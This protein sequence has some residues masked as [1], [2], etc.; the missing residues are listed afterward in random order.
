M[1]NT[2]TV[3]LFIWF[4][5][6][7]FWI[8]CWIVP[9]QGQ[10]QQTCSLPISLCCFQVLIN[11]S[12]LTAQPLA[13]LTDCSGS[14]HFILYWAHS[15]CSQLNKN[16]SLNLFSGRSN[17]PVIAINS[18]ES[19][20]KAALGWLNTGN[21]PCIMPSKTRGRVR[22]SDRRG[23]HKWCPLLVV[24]VC[25]F[26]SLMCLSS[27]SNR[28]LPILNS[29]MHSLRKF[30]R[31]QWP[32]NVKVAKSVFCVLLV[33]SSMSQAKEIITAKLDDC[34]KGKSDQKTMGKQ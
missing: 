7:H 9:E 21:P 17:A 18:A 28:G 16:R 26:F 32:A 8:A 22:S 12:I 3:T 19:N 10:M 4:D 11:Q 13:Q 30:P 14:C 25:C 34:K 1:I 24:S 2:D 33:L 6:F 23:V 29:H 31:L 5:S 27:L 15:L 20:N